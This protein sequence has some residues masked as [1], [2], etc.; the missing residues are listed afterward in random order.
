MGAFSRSGPSHY[1]PTTFGVL[2]TRNSADILPVNLLF[3]LD[4]VCERILVVDNGSTDKTKK[5][6]RR[7]A[8]RHP[9][10][11]LSDDGEFRQAEIFTELASEAR[12]KGAEWV[13]PL[14]SDEFWR[15]TRPIPEVIA[16]AQGLGLGA[17]TV[18]R[19]EFVQARDQA[20]AEPAA[21]LRATMRVGRPGDHADGLDAFR[22]GDRSMFELIPPQKLLMR[23]SDG[24]VIERGAHGASGLD[25]PVGGT[26]EVSVLH[27]PFRA[28]SVA[29]SRGE[30]GR[31]VSRL[32]EDPDVSFQNRQWAQMES[33]G[34]LDEMWRAHS[35]SDGALDVAGRRVELIEDPRLA[36]LLRP[37]LVTHSRRPRLKTAHR[38]K[39]QLAVR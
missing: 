23:L 27:L 16:G 31:R 5:V 38:R 11:W 7:L 32:I 3:H 10:D 2:V 13:V 26:S 14:D 34:R 36:E 4:T 6:L 18:P 8:R 33:E 22:R 35:Y 15:G 19:V 20:T 29:G 21:L 37:W 9:I 25:G 24:L 39:A 30:H 28:L 17:L 1:G 12:R